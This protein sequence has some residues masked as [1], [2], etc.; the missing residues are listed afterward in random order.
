MHPRLP[1]Q[2]VPYRIR[3]YSD[4]GP[5]CRLTNSPLIWLRFLRRFTVKVMAT[6]IIAAVLTLLIVI[7]LAINNNGTRMYFTVYKNF[8]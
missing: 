4:V 7:L 2:Q 3:F 1:N 8:L 5:R 6:G